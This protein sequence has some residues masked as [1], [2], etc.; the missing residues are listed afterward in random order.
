MSYQRTLG[1]P[2]NGTF[3]P[4]LPTPGSYTYNA[5]GTVATDADGNTY[6]YNADGTVHTVAKGGVTRT[7]TYNADGTVGSVA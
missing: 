3:A 7:L 5:D 4:V 1:P 6:T 2:G